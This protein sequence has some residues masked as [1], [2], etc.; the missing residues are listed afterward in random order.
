LGT[1]LAFGRLSSDS[2]ITAFKAS[3]MSLF[4]T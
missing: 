3:G 2:E 1:L 4:Q